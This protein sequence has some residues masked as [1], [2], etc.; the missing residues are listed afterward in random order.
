MTNNKKD[1][2]FKNIAGIIVLIIVLLSIG[3]ASIKGY[4][5]ANHK[6]EISIRKTLDF[7]DKENPINISLNEQIS[8]YNEEK[9]KEEERILLEKENSTKIAYLTFDDGP[10][11]MVT[12]EI[13]EVLDNYGIKATFFVLGKMAEINPETL[14][15]VYSSGHSIGNHGYSHN[16]KYIYI[17]IDNFLLDI[18]KSNKTLKGI[19]GEDFQTGLLRLPGGSFG[20]SK[21]KYVNIAEEKGYRTYDWNALNGDA[22]VPKKN[23]NQLVQRL[24]DTARGRKKIVILMHDTDAKK[25]TAKALP[26]IIDYL[27]GEGYSFKALEQ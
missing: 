20:K 1:Y 17:N 4:T 3:I 21:N 9:K 18:E 12:K 10:S 11:Q 6:N 22:E 8:L 24:K 23:K 26:E 14:K 19:L 15:L 16:Y 27:I 7:I 25:N 13:I 2:N 5:Q